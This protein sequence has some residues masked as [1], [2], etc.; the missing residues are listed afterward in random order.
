MFRAFLVYAVE[1]YSRIPA[2]EDLLRQ[3]FKGVIQTTDTPAKT[4]Q[5]LEEL[6]HRSGFMDWKEIPEPEYKLGVTEIALNVN[7]YH[8]TWG[9][10]FLALKDRL[11][12]HWV[13]WVPLK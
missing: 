10:A 11:G 8:I 7:P 5:V 12:I 1:D 13:R 9:V 2:V 4:Q 3:D 6:E